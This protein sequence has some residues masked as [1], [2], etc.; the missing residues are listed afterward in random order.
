MD[1]ETHKTLGPLTTFS[2]GGP[3]SFFCRVTQVQ[4]LQ[5]A[6]LFA[7]EHALGVC[8][9]GG[10]SNV[11]MPDEGFNGLV[12]KIEIKGIELQDIPGHASDRLLVAGAGESW[13]K[14]VEYAIT[15]NLWGIEN[16]SAIPGSVGGAVVQNIGAYG[17]AVSETLRWVEVFDSQKLQTNRMSASECLFGYRS[18][19]FKQ[20]EHLVV[21]RAAYRLSSMPKLNLEYKD[22]A[23]KFSVFSDT[24]TL[25]AVREAVVSIRKKKFPDLR[26]EGTAGSFFKNPIVS[27]EAAKIL[28]E[29]FPGMPLFLLPE[30]TGIKIPLAWLLDHVLNLKGFEVGGARLFEKQPLVIA[31]SRTASAQ[32]VIKL[33]T[34][35]REKIKKEFLIDIEPEVKIIFNKK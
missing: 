13:D 32:D 4:E 2:I 28:A 3:A 16:L 29:K 34:I 33:S 19:I 23:Q 24:P 22:L 26:L 9:L 6:F 30:S 27:P 5:E 1:I 15:N 8:I 17:T 18:S 10:G 12:I 20:Q 21:A 31:A 7:Q 25:Q 14:I 11:L 35:V